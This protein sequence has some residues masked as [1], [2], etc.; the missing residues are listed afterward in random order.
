M[1]IGRNT[2]CPCGSGRKYKNCCL[3]VEEGARLAEGPGGPE[4]RRA[5][6][7]ANEWEVDLVPLVIAIGNDPTARPC[8]VLVV[9]AGLV[10]HA[11]MLS[12]P[13]P[14]PEEVASEL[15]REILEVARL[16]ETD[17]RRIVVRRPEVAAPLS[18]LLG[19]AGWQVPVD[20]GSLDDL[21][22]A[23]LSL[24]SSMAGEPPGSAPIGAPVTWAGWGLPESWCDELFRAAAAFYR[25]A[26]WTYLWDA[27]TLEIAAPSGRTWTR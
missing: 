4:L 11:N 24:R 9:A 10:L 20:V 14:E 26:P 19:T 1:K 2:P 17:P 7:R 8:V 18:A 22:E 13:S 25:A 27:D 3:R 16:L 12:R 23:S 6:R 21:D 15:A 5:A